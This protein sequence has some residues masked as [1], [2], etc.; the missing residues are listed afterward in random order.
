MPTRRYSNHHRRTEPLERIDSHI[1]YTFAQA[2][3]ED[4]GGVVNAERDI[5]A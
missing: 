3:R 4:L 2:L 1:P 5:T